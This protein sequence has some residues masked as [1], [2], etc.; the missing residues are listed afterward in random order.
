MRDYAINHN[1]KTLYHLSSAMQIGGSIMMGGGFG[2]EN[3]GLPGSMV[4]NGFINSMNSSYMNS[5]P[6]AGF[7]SGAGIAGLPALFGTIGEMGIGKNSPF[8][9]KG[10][11]KLIKGGRGKIHHLWDNLMYD[12][13]TINS[14]FEGGMKY[15]PGGLSGLNLLSRPPITPANFLAANADYQIAYSLAYARYFGRSYNIRSDELFDFESMYQATSIN[16]GSTRIVRQGRIGDIEFMFAPDPNVYAEQVYYWSIGRP[17][18]GIGYL[19]SNDI[20]ESWFIKSPYSRMSP[21][22]LRLTSNKGNIITLYYPNYKE[23]KRWS[24]FIRQPW[25]GF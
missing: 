14:M 17:G 15:V 3:V 6:V 12:F 16:S 10:T 20:D 5:S 23:L 25:K 24:N 7:I 13:P 2:I 8:P 18:A 1:N 9:L 21:Y 4:G 19:A 22:S 11:G